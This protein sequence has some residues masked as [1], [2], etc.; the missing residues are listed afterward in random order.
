MIRSRS[1]SRHFVSFEDAHFY[2]Q[3]KESQ[4]WVMLYSTVTEKSGLTVS[5]E[6][7]RSGKGNMHCDYYGKL[8]RKKETCCKL[9]GKPTRGHGRKRVDPS[10]GQPNIAK[11]METSRENNF[12]EALSSDEVQHFRHLLNNTFD[13]GYSGIAFNSHLYSWIIGSSVNR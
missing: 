2:V 8:R 11:H 5:Y 12:G 10:R 7:P 9:Y 6:Q 4:Q 1:S 13:Y 3:Q